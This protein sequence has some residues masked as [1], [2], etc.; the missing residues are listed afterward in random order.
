MTLLSSLHNVTVHQLI[1]LPTLDMFSLVNYNASFFFQRQVP[2]QEAWLALGSAAKLASLWLCPGSYPQTVT[3]RLTLPHFVLRS[4]TA[5]HLTSQ[6]TDTTLI[7]VTIT[8]PL[9]LSLKL[10]LAALL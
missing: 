8:C 9:G 6:S 7:E 5:V 4:L 1:T 10:P 3:H 2:S